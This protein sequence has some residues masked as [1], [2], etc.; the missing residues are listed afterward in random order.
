MKRLITIFVSSIIG[1]SL[2]G[3]GLPVTIVGDVYIAS[4][5][6]MESQGPVHL[7]AIDKDKVAK[8]ANYGTLK[9][10]DALIFYSNDSADGLLMN[11]NITGTPVSA[12]QVIMRKA[13]AVSNAW[14]QVSFPFE[15]NLTNGVLDPQDPQIGGKPLKYNAGAISSGTYNSSAFYVQEYSTEK[16]AQVGNSQDASGEDIWQTVGITKLEKGKGY[17]IAVKLTNINGYNPGDIVNVDFVASDIGTLFD[18]SATPKSVDLAFYKSSFFGHSDYSEGWNAIGGLN[19]TNFLINRTTIGFTDP[20]YG[21]NS[22]ANKWEPTNPMDISLVGTLRPYA[23]I[24]AQVVNGDKNLPDGPNVATFTY[25]SSG[26]VLDAAD[27]NFIFRSSSSVDYDLIKLQLTSVKNN[28][29]SNVYFQFNDNYTQTF[30]TSEGD[31]VLMQSFSAT[32]PSVWALAQ[33]ENN[34]KDVTFI[35]CLPYNDN[36]VPIGVDIPAAGD[37]VFS[38]KDVTV[39]KG[40]ESAVLRDNATGINTDLLKSDYT[41]QAD[42]AI[43]SENR[44]VLFINKTITSIDQITTSDIYAY[45]ENNTLTV[46]N[47]DSGDRVQVL[48]LTGH[49]IAS[50]IAIGNTYSTTINQKGVYI[51]RA[52]GGAKILKVLN[53]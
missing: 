38:L 4:D 46:K 6:I 5:G 31:R 11:Q 24:F 3:Q 30:K 7:Q 14:Y 20:V 26:L 23:V 28:F 39:T 10:D 32:A 49:I 53:K 44:F 51:V 47:L 12:S 29:T 45:A 36:E 9:V 21:W 43:N 35:D 27:P 41:V 19:S 15:V 34:E 50:G 37:Y 17:R 52:R 16:R 40:I 22:S 18:A 48:D 25:K 33:N 42:G 13:F 8:V 2:W 1:I